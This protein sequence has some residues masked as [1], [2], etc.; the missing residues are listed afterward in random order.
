MEDLKEQKVG[1]LVAE[2][3]KYADIFKKHHIDFCCGGG[4]SVSE[5]CQ[6]KGLNEDELLQELESIGNE[7]AIDYDYKNWELDKLTEH[8]KR[9]HHSYVRESLP[10]LESYSTKVAKVHG[11]EH[12]E[13]KEVKQLV[14]ALAEELIPH[15][16]KEE[17]VLF[18][19][20]NNLV[21]SIRLGKEASPAPFGTIQNPV[22]AMIHEHDVAGDIMKKLASLTGDFTPPEDACNT[23]SVLYHKLEEFQNDLFLHIH[24][25]NN[26]L[27]PKA[28]KLE[29]Q[30]TDNSHLHR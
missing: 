7:R 25:E 18:P 24:L 29:V 9:I 22:S 20:I 26:I 11:D 23:Y 21:L 2:N 13:T 16:N 15:L 5:V 10:I 1:V 27:F 3:Y 12:P 28:K 14:D 6:K 30:V 4:I 8:I 19:Y 17:I